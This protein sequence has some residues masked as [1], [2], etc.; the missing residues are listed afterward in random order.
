ML[1]QFVVPLEALP[2]VLKP[3][4]VHLLGLLPLL[5]FELLKLRVLLPKMVLHLLLDKLFTGHGF[6][7]N[8]ELGLL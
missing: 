8:L 4:T 3:L 5:V 6:L 2:L 1:L 7:L